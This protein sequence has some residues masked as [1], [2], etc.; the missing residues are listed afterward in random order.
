[1]Y[2]IFDLKVLD[3]DHTQY[4]GFFSRANVVEVKWSG[5]LVGA[6]VDHNMLVRVY[7][8]VYNPPVSGV[9][10]VYPR[11]G[12]PPIGGDIRTSWGQNNIQV[13]PSSQAWSH[14][15]ANLTNILK[16]CVRLDKR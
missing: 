11:L 9:K 7:A 15:N 13:V 5:E 12:R 3:D 14:L 16:R 10:Q 4:V 1:M 6:T 8:V 2:R